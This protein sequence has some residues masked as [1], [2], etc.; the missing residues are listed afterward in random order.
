MNV[1]KKF[2]RNMSE[3]KEIFS[4]EKKSWLIS[5]Q[6][7]TFLENPPSVA[8]IPKEKKYIN[9]KMLFTDLGR[10]VLEKKAELS[11]SFFQYGPLGQ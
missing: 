5:V 11:G 7:T 1:R 2:D 8:R 4:Q 6:F 9:I 10:S 3:K